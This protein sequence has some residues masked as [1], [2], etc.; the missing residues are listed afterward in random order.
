MFTLE[1]KTQKE[2]FIKTIEENIIDILDQFGRVRRATIHYILASK[3]LISNPGE[4]T[5]WGPKDPMSFQ[6]IINNMEKKGLIVMSKSRAR[7]TFINLV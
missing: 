7:G 6:G 4:G 5:H 1:T 2:L 3:G